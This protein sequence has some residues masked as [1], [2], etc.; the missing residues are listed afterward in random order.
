[1]Y[2]GTTDFGFANSSYYYPDEFTLLYDFCKMNKGA[3]NSP[4]DPGCGCPNT[5]TVKRPVYTNA[6]EFKQNVT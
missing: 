3:L 2:C 1:M 5:G 4:S 6:C